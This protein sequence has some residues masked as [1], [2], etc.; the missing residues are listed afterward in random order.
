MEQINE[1]QNETVN[2]FFRGWTPLR[3][4]APA[5]RWAFR[6]K[7]S[8]LSPFSADAGEKARETRFSC[9]LDAA[10]TPVDCAFC[11]MLS[12]A[13]FPCLMAWATGCAPNILPTR[14]RVSSW[15][16]PLADVGSPIGSAACAHFRNSRQLK[17]SWYNA[18]IRLKKYPATKSV[19]MKIINNLTKYTGL[20]LL[21][22][23]AT[24]QTPAEREARAFINT[25][26]TI[27]NAHEACKEKIK[28]IYLTEYSYA[29][30]KIA[31]SK[32]KEPA[33]YKEALNRNTI[34]TP[35][36]SIAF[37]KYSLANSECLNSTIDRISTNNAYLGEPIA[38]RFL[39]YQ[40]FTLELLSREISV[41]EF[42]KKQEFKN[43]IF[44]SEMKIRLDNYKNDLIARDQSE[45]AIEFSNRMNAISKGLQQMSNQLNES[46]RTQ[47]ESLNRGNNT[48][49]VI[50]GNIINC[51]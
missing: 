42:L 38:D 27:Q 50:N 34:L 4:L 17:F 47:L 7:R 1:L 41:S 5:G 14:G 28:D 23:C 30:T 25:M 8:P 22:G 21:T 24:V 51:F 37:G 39:S 10:L 35:D 11:P 43:E 20:I 33:L 18:K 16:G 36:E 49:C 31:P 29:T 9:L 40:T 32:K 15:L 2:G 44:Q 3:T 19:N 12:Q 48:T 46:H 6:T 45:K 13:G 26:Q